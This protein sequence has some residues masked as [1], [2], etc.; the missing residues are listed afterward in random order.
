MRRKDA[1][2]CVM[3]FAWN[4]MDISALHPSYDP[5]PIYICT[6]FLSFLILITSLCYYSDT[7]RSLA[8]VCVTKPVIAKKT[9]PMKKY[10]SKHA[11]QMHDKVS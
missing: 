9:F 3:S 7:V 1:S 11:K 2:V 10:A 6:F 4:L 5:F 8:L